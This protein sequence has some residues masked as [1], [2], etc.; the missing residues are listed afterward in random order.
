M[1]FLVVIGHW[2]TENFELMDIALDFRHL[3]YPHTGMEKKNALDGV[4]EEFGIKGKLF[5]ITMDNATN[6]D[7]AYGQ[8]LQDYQGLIHIRCAADCIN[9]CCQA[10][11]GVIQK[12]ISRLSCLITVVSQPKTFQVLYL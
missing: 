3:P 4:L 1:P 7:S 9:L 6:M 11:F 2:F 8:L 5:A 12:E 10:G